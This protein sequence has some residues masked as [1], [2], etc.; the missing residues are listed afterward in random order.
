MTDW[1]AIVTATLQVVGYVP[2]R[3]LDELMEELSEYTAIADCV[4]GIRFSLA[5]Q[6]NRR[7]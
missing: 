5:K 1:G 2:Q 7:N 4:A 3:V 6:R